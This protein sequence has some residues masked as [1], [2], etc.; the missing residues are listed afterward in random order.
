MWPETKL[1]G[2]LTTNGKDNK[3]KE[4]EEKQNPH[5][6]PQTQGTALGR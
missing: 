1:H 5:Q 6:E 2:R 3:S 4:K